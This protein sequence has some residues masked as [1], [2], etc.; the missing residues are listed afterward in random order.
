MTSPTEVATRRAKVLQLAQGGA[1]S[2]QIADEL[3][4]SKD[5]VLRDLRQAD[6]PPAT[7]IER[8]AHR[9]AQADH[10]VRQACAAAQSVADINPASV[11][12]DDATADAWRRSLRATVAQLVAQVEAFNDYYPCATD[13]PLTASGSPR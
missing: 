12:T 7:Q 6:A 3:G 8:L 4:V 1:S 2:R 10:A 13:A 5:T 11:F 9:V